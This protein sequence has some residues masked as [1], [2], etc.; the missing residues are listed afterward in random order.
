[1]TLTLCVCVECIGSLS[2][3]KP[4][5]QQRFHPSAKHLLYKH[6]TPSFVGRSFRVKGEICTVPFR[7][8]I[9]VHFDSSSNIFSCRYA[10]TVELLE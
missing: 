3:T 4:T 7:Q 5:M 2:L 6:N 9:A 10:S 8:I 1:M